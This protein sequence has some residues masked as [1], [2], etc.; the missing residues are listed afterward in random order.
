M[1]DRLDEVPAFPDPPLGP[2]RDVWSNRH[3]PEPE[4]SERDW[5]INATLFLLT[6]L[7]VFAA[8]GHVFQI[9]ASS[10]RDFARALGSD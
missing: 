2:D 8:G 9:E 10:F 5:R 7:S 1:S 3:G 6:V 4:P